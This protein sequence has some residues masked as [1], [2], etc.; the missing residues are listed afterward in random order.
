MSRSLIGS[1][2]DLWEAYETDR[3]QDFEPTSTT[4]FFL[5]LN[6]AVPELPKEFNSISMKGNNG[7]LNVDDINGRLMDVNKK[8]YPVVHCGNCH[9]EHAYPSITIG[10]RYI[11]GAKVDIGEIKCMGCG[12][13]VKFIRRAYK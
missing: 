12:T 9:M 13:R 10:K 8:A 7:K 4:R 11:K 3:V 5:D 2:E 1:V 6:K